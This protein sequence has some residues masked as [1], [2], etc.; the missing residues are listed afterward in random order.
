MYFSIESHLI[1]IGQLVMS[2]VWSWSTVLKHMCD[3][4]LFVSSLYR[5]IL[6]VE[7]RL[8]AT[9]LERLFS[10]AIAQW[11]TSAFPNLGSGIKFPD[12]GTERGFCQ[13][14]EARRQPTDVWWLPTTF[15]CSVFSPDLEPNLNVWT[16]SQHFNAKSVSPI[17]KLKKS[18]FSQMTSTDL[19]PHYIAPTSGYNLG[20]TRYSIMVGLSIGYILFSVMWNDWNITRKL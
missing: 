19:L 12:S 16:S 8:E 4:N 2:Y 18:R 10:W 3:S 20:Y 14:E 7:V 6:E 17:R 13:N 1:M 15:G 5:A 9:W 11:L